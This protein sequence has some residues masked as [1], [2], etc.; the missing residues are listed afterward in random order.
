MKLNNFA[1]ITNKALNLNKAIYFL[2]VF[3]VLFGSYTF[4]AMTK[5]LMPVIEIPVITVVTTM[6]GSSAEDMEEMVTE[7]IEEELGD[8][9][10]LEE[11]R[12]RSSK[13]VSTLILK[14]R[15]NV[16][17]E[18]ALQDVERRMSSI[19][20]KLP[21]DASSPMVSDID[22]SA[23]PTALI[24]INA[25]RPYNTQKKVIDELKY[26]LGKIDGIKSVDAAG[27]KK[28][29]VNI[30]PDTR[31]MNKYNI[32]NS[33][34]VNLIKDRSTDIPLGE[35]DINGMVYSFETDNKIKSLEELRNIILISMR[36]RVVRLR[37][38]AKVEYEDE[39]SISK[40]YVI[41]G[42][43]KTRVVSLR[44]FLKQDADSIKVNDACKALVKK[45]NAEFPSNPIS[46]SLDTSVYIKNSISDISTNAF[47]G[48]LSV[49]VVLF[50][51]INLREAVIASFIIPIT[52]ITSIILFKPFGLSINMLS[53][54]GL[55]I[56]LGMLVDNAIVVIE[57]IDENRIVFSNRSFKEV[58]LLSI[59]KV[60][61]AIFSSTVTT[62][63]AFIPLAFLSGPIGS[64]IRSIPIAMAISISLSFIVS[65]TLTPVLAYSFLNAYKE[66]DNRILKLFTMLVVVLCAMYAF[67]NDFKL[68]TLSYI[69]GVVVLIL[70]FMKLFVKSEAYSYVR[71]FDKMINAII[72]SRVLQGLV[73]VF[74][75]S[76]FVYSMSLLASN[77]I[78]KENFP[79]YDEPIMLVKLSLVEGVGSDVSDAVF[80]KAEEILTSK[81]YID[82]YTAFVDVT[83]HSYFIELK[84]GE[85]KSNLEIF[86]EL[87][88]EL[89][90]IPDVD[91][92]VST[93]NRS[94][95]PILIRLKGDNYNDLITEANNMVE[96]LKSVSGVVNPKADYDY[97]N[98]VAKVV[99]D[100]EKA[101]KNNILI[102]DISL[103]IRNILSGEKLG[104]LE[105]DGNNVLLYIRYD[106]VIND[107]RDIK[108]LSILTRDNR[109]IPLND[110]VRIEEY[111]TLQALNHKDAKRVI[112]VK[113]SNEE[114]TTVEEIVKEFEKKLKERGGVGLGVKYSI[115][116][117]FDEM[118]KSYR[119]LA[120]KFII[121]LV[122][123]YVV[124]L[125]QFN[126][127][128]QP[129][130]IILCV[131]FSI[132]GVSIGYFITGLT[133][134]T[135]TFLGI[136]SLVGIGINDAIVLIDFI[137]QLRR[138]GVERAESI[139]AGAKSRLKPIITTSLTTIT[140]VMPLALYSPDYS[141]MAYAL[142]FGLVSSTFLTLIVIPSVLNIIESF[143]LVFKRK[144]CEI[145][146]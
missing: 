116:G 87:T 72:K 38:V 130:V 8:I 146:K 60:G 11:V 47:S 30:V 121:A 128:F 58:I 35:K 53:I 33:T 17:T 95:A 40:N 127:F 79:E 54:I 27:I 23:F 134:S 102:S 13:N 138:D 56:A 94:T 145:E 28:P 123:V 6:V 97:G 119:D 64:M 61:S 22:V 20:N 43:E 14:F 141:Q 77:K 93:N 135:L 109:L 81:D 89:G 83:S 7:V 117:E 115:G 16:D 21:E 140:G 71:V 101:A 120:V 45:W 103:K 73:I 76:L 139:I 44:V 104:N 59:N 42:K 3:I 10:N 144:D 18:K 70:S 1:K 114:G 106:G 143:G 133:F 36:G 29:R 107:V 124:L 24:N 66:G 78:P 41:Q 82:L 48:I 26:R 63:C 39:Y 25:D 122:L 9:E 67:S 46:L 131:P 112:E 12:S 132:I 74:T 5:T 126:S 34:L 113:A 118:G 90:R 98:E 136:I 15:E 137:N 62:I 105:M 85:R 108:N 100:K 69:V 55:I 32:S 99:I 88:T 51:F 4:S 125:L 37:D 91:V 142:V 52:L 111:R 84:D 96:V 65:I 129:L 86:K 31:L 2:V 80:D 57:M 19:K 68:T 50:L 110:F 75:L 49:I 92:E